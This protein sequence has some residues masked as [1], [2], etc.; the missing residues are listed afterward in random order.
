MFLDLLQDFLRR[1]WWGV[2]AGIVLIIG[3]IWWYASSQMVMISGYRVSKANANAA[4]YYSTGE[5]DK[6]QT[7]YETITTKQ[8]RDWFAWNGLAN[9]YRDKNQYGLAETAYLKSLDINPK[10][11]QGYR[12]IFNLYYT[13]SARDNDPS[14]LGKSEPIL[15]QGH[16]L[17]S[18]SATVLEDLVSYYAK[19]N[20]QTQLKVYKDKLITVQSGE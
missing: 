3:G 7:A 17:L 6:A 15:L 16:K 1:Y 2:V 18:K 9:I 4:E 14:L 5:I 20:D 10:F 8:P 11:E 13:W 12:N 19:I